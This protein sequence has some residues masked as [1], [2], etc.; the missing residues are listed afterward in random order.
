[1]AADRR[2]AAEVAAADP[3]D[4][5]AVWAG[6]FA[7]DG[8]QIVP[9]TVVTGHETITALMDGAFTSPGFALEWDPDT[10][11][12]SPDGQLGWTSGRYVSRG[13]GPEGEVVTEGRYLTIWRRLPDGAWK[14]D[15]D[16]GVPDE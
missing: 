6:W 5:G 9:G 10:A 11:A 8:R 1:M 2:F 16:T 15:L 14:V 7:P 4:R 3:A 12:A 13:I